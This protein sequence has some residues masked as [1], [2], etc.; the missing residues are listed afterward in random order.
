MS[1]CDGNGNVVLFNEDNGSYQSFSNSYTHHTPYIY[2]IPCGAFEGETLNCM[3]ANKSLHC[4]KAS[5]FNDRETFVKIKDEEDAATCQ[6]IGRSVRNFDDEVWQR[7]V[8]G[9]AFQVAMQKFQ[10]NDHLTTLLLSTSGSLLA[11]ASLNSVWGTGLELTHEHAQ[12]PTQWPGQNIQGEALMKVRDELRKRTQPDAEHDGIAKQRAGCGQPAAKVLRR[13]PDW[14]LEQLKKIPGGLMD[15]VFLPLQCR[16]WSQSTPQITV[17]DLNNSVHFKPALLL[18]N[19]LSEQEADA[20]R[21]R[22]SEMLAIAAADDCRC[23]QMLSSCCSFNS[24][25]LILQSFA[26]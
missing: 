21:G 9:V 5:V 18:R 16:S 24:T 1:S 4:T 25:L 10:G 26:V 20:I 3:N 2:T 15:S 19:V 12:V 17:V 22:V 14:E 13:T 8:N 11:E 6:Q 7:Y 23:F